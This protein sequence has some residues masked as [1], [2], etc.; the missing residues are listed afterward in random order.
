[1][2]D[3]KIS[4][5]EASIEK[6]LDER[7]DARTKLRRMATLAENALDN[8]RALAEQLETLVA[9]LREAGHQL[10]LAG[11]RFAAA[12]VAEALRKVGHICP[13]TRADLEKYRRETPE[14]QIETLAA[15][16]NKIRDLGYSPAAVIAN[17]ALREAGRG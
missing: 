12:D 10:M 3:S 5:S 17:A 2:A 9:A 11:F 8:A 7:D 13:G 15:A 6:W 16:L 1:M 14:A 4:V